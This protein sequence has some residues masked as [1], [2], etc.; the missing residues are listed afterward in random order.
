MSIKVKI[1]TRQFKQFVSDFRRKLDRAIP[2]A[3]NRSGNKVRETILDRT[4]RGVGLSGRFKRY[5][6][7]Y[8]DYRKDKGRGSTPDLNFS[9]RMLSNID[10]ERAGT[11]KVL[12]NFKRKEEGRK[13]SINQKK[14]PFFGVR[15]QEK[16]F[17][18]E[19]FAK[20]LRK[21]L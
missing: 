12:V 10:V 16:K 6:R 5:S 7:E 11:N 19:V 18:G 21:D 4:S 15:P 3:L 20:Q 8:A 17:I 9:G 1:H 2:K 13:A 14:R